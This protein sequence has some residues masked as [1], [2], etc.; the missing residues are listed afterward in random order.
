[1][2]KEKTI[3][4]Q[5]KAPGLRTTEF[6]PLLLLQHPVLVLVFKQRLFCGGG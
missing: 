3:S 4:K 1:M 6:Q 5:T 2:N